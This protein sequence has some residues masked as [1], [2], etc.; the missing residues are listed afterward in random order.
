[1][2]A[3]TDQVEGDLRRGLDSATTANLPE[4]EKTGEKVG[5]RLGDGVEKEVGRAGPRIARSLVDG[6][7]KESLDIKPKLR[8]NLRGKNGQFISRAVDSIQEEVEDAFTRSA[9]SGGGGIFSKIGQGF[10]DAIGAS[11][12]ISGR[13]P[14][15]ALLI[16]LFGSIAAAIGAAIQ[17]VNGLA[18]AFA[19]LPAVIGAVGLQVGVLLLAFDGIGEAISGVFAATNVKEFNEALKGL[20]P[21][22]QS[23]VKSLIPLRDLFRDLKRSSQQ[24]FFLGLGNA[25][26]KVFDNVEWQLRTSVDDI[27]F[28]LGRAAATVLGVF[29]GPEFDHFINRIIP[30]TLHWINSFGPALA[31][32]LEGLIQVA[33]AS[34]PF[35][36]KLGDLLTSGLTYLGDKLLEVTASGG[37]NDWLNS[38][39]DTLK[40]LGPLLAATFKVIASFLATLNNA[41]GVE[42][43]KTITAILNQFAAFLATEAGFR[44]MVAIV[45]ILINSLYVF[46][47]SVEAVLFLIA[48]V[49][50]FVVWLTGTALP[51]VGDFFTWVGDKILGLVE[52]IKGW[53]TSSKD[54]VRAFATSLPS[55]IRD[56]I[57]DLGT[58]L[59][60]AGK[61]LIQGLI[62]GIKQAIPNLRNALSSITNMLPDWKGPEDKDR[63]IL[64]PAGEAVMEGFGQGLVN[65]AYDIRNLLGDFTD[66]I[67]GLAMN[68]NTST[69]NFGANAINVN[70]TGSVPTQAQ[71]NAA[72]SAVGAGVMD[73]LA[74]RSTRIAVRTL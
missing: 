52:K 12:N 44:A 62:N 17:A 53:F 28:A 38:M 67:G 66:G 57:G 47:F 23:F 10:S 59:L 8:W 25:V 36:S 58:L 69:V 30:A 64:V 22:A 70:F 72:G 50:A 40:S 14:L 43:I 27:A 60:N 73:Q 20:T 19:T 54:E 74:A 41:G 46:I 5:G 3:N 31:R 24:G 9:A 35:L 6:V 34:I 37:F 15:I 21:A 29:A 61:N 7:E 13:S 4:A 56:A 48:S 32:V 2:H 63:K 16:P 1:V 39:L 33:D 11:F 26:T 71:M 51:A 55:T 45:E 18:A 42:L 49:Q 65:G 68:S